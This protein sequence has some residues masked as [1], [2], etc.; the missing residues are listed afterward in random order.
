MHA[1]CGQRLA[2]V[3]DSI[4][5]PACN[6]SVEEHKRKS[7]FLSVGII[8]VLFSVRV[9]VDTLALFQCPGNP[10]TV[11]HL[12]NPGSRPIAVEPERRAM[13]TVTC[14]VAD[15]RR[16]RDPPGNGLKRASTQLRGRA[17]TEK[18]LSIL[19][20]DFLK[21]PANVAVAVKKSLAT[22][23]LLPQ[24]SRVARRSCTRV[25]GIVPAS[26]EKS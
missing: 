22:R 19:A 7:S 26:A 1:S 5:C 15:D 9:D 11:G 2:P 25:F 14:V 16:P 24:R 12:T 21:T 18:L 10:L 17:F 20:I 6:G 23:R 4:E 13:T 3:Y 8:V